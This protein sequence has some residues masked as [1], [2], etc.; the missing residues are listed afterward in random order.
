MHPV[1][2]DVFSDMDLPDGAPR[3]AHWPKT[4]PEDFDAAWRAWQ[5]TLPEGWDRT[6]PEDDG[7]PEEGWSDAYRDFRARWDAATLGTAPPEK[8]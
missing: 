4:P 6:W 3:P 8:G 5:A 2:P 1:W 7:R